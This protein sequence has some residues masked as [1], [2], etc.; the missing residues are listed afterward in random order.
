MGQKNSIQ[1][2]PPTYEAKTTYKIV[3]YKSRECKC[4]PVTGKEIY[5]I[6]FKE[7]TYMVSKKDYNRNLYEYIECYKIKTTMGE[8]VNFA[9]ITN[10]IGR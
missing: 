8:P 9:R 10:V 6:K 3:H 7:G 2:A 5:Y 4:D 1:K